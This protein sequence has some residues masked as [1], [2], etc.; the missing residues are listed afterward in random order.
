MFRRISPSPSLFLF[1]FSLFLLKAQ[2]Y[3]PWTALGNKY[4]YQ[5][6]SDVSPV[7]LSTLSAKIY[8]VCR[9]RCK[10]G[11]LHTELRL[12]QNI[13]Y[14]WFPVVCRG[15]GRSVSPV[16]LPKLISVVPGR[17]RI[18]GVVL[19]SFAVIPTCT[20][21]DS[22]NTNSS[23]LYSAYLSLYLA[24]SMLAALHRESENLL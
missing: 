7:V 23:S 19:P 10:L 9:M 20:K 22:K 15:D 11:R 3:E 18:A 1:S 14:L 13:K 12:S 2:A 6:S 8:N 16:G 5:F 21:S 4:L 24:N 17:E